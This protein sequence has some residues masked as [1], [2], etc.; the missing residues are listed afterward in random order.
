L[1]PE[2]LP[3][4]AAAGE[5]GC[6]AA[7]SIRQAANDFVLRAWPVDA[8]LISRIAIRF[9]DFRAFSRHQKLPSHFSEAGAAIF[10]VE[11]VEYGGHDHP[12]RLITER[13]PTTN[14]G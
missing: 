10:A 2:L 12:H 3:L 9:Q 14:F 7:A 13:I 5:D 8:T 11:Q 6:F 1:P 4:A